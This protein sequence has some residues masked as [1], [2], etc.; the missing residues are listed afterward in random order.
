MDDLNSVIDARHRH[1]PMSFLDILVSMSHIVLSAVVLVEYDMRLPYGHALT[2]IALGTLTFATVYTQPRP[3]CEWGVAA[4]GIVFCASCLIWIYA[5]GIN[6]MLSLAHSSSIAPVVSVTYKRNARRA[7][8]VTLT[9]AAH[10]CR[11]RF[12]GV[13]ILPEPFSYFSGGVLLSLTL[14]RAWSQTRQLPSVIYKLPTVLAGG[15]GLQKHTTGAQVVVGGN[16]VRTMQSSLAHISLANR[17][18]D[19]Q[20]VVDNVDMRLGEFGTPLPSLLKPAPSI[21]GS[22]LPTTSYQPYA[23]VN[24]A[25]T[26]TDIDTGFGVESCAATDEAVLKQL[27]DALQQHKWSHAAQLSSG[28]GQ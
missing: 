28:V 7:T 4:R 24:P 22:A 8:T 13:M 15:T 6:D 10:L 9:Q 18:G 14:F 20:R 11:V 5:I 27:Q 21:F 19:S 2:N 12:I 26:C 16:T 25:Q 1:F 3:A 23:T 17:E